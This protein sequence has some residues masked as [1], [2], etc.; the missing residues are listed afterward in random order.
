MEGI[1]SGQDSSLVKSDDIIVHAFFIWSDTIA[2][3]FP[4][5]FL[6]RSQWGFAHLRNDLVL[7]D[8]RWRRR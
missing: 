2:A 1:V 8:V 4:F 3:T 5:P 7:R 6:G